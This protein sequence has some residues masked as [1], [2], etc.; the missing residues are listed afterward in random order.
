[1]K[2]ET[3]SDLNGLLNRY[4]K[5]LERGIEQKEVAKKQQEAFTKEYERVKTDT[6]RPVMERIGDKLE[7]HGHRYQISEEDESRDYQ[8]R[9]SDPKITMR[10]ASAGQERKSLQSMDITSVSFIAKKS[11]EKVL[12]HAYIS[13]ISGSGYG[14][15]LGEVDLDILTNEGVERLITEVLTSMFESK[16]GSIKLQT[17]LKPH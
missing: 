4:D 12:V 15:P 11:S 7:Q 10:I 16:W 9:V 6:I 2:K 13:M 14:G 8:L 5:R 17:I 3:E 1:V